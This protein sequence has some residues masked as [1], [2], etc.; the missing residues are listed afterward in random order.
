MG[1][2]GSNYDSNV[3]RLERRLKRRRIANTEFEKKPRKNALT[4]IENNAAK[5]TMEL[6]EYENFVSTNSYEHGDYNDDVGDHNLDP[7]YKMFLQNVKQDGQSYAVVVFEE[8]GVNELL[9]YEIVDSESDERGLETREGVESY[10]VNKKVNSER[11]LRR[12]LN[13]ENTEIANGLAD[14]SSEGRDGWSP[15]AL[16]YHARNTRKRESVEIL[17]DG[18]S[19]R[20]RRCSAGRNAGSDSSARSVLEDNYFNEHEIGHDGDV[21]DV[22]NGRGKGCLAQKRAGRERKGLNSGA[23]SLR[24]GSEGKRLVENEFECD[25][26]SVDEEYDRFLNSINVG[27]G[28]E[29]DFFDQH[30]SDREDDV[31]DEEY[32][33]VLNSVGRS[34]VRLGS[35]GSFSDQHQSDHEE[36]ICDEEEDQLT[37]VSEDE[38]DDSD[39]YYRL[40]DRVSGG[41][42]GQSSTMPQFEGHHL[43]ESECDQEDVFDEIDEDY[44]TFLNQLEMDGEATMYK[45]DGNPERFDE[46]E[47]SDSDIEIMDKDPYTGGATTPF[48]SSRQCIDVENYGFTEDPSMR[49]SQFK[50]GLMEVLK[51][52]YDSKEHEVLKGEVSCRKPITRERVMRNHTKSYPVEKLGKSYLD[53]YSGYPRS[54]GHGMVHIS[55]DQKF[56]PWLDLSCLEVLP[57]KVTGTRRILRSKCKKI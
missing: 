55:D 46:V 6:E 50:K 56:K 40:T 27:L 57:Q 18:W 11:I 45:I 9:R 17:D 42:K 26:D 23:T 53:L 3:A 41:M 25:D 20:R 22:P 38:I 7:Q 34:H 44:A 32:D 24:S 37:H 47:E 10:P 19:K 2:E 8:N 52:P 43:V 48:V 5:E 14:F 49:C 21:G 12:D 28:S 51:M 4:V 35:E 1:L 31:E 13:G 15:R 39:E 36:E 29:G 16:R 54:D 30:G 33:C